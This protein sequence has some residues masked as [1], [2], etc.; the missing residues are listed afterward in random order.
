MMT[1]ESLVI[2]LNIIVDAPAVSTTALVP[3]GSTTRLVLITFIKE[4]N[5][6]IAGIAQNR[7][8]S[9]EV[10]FVRGT[11]SSTHTYTLRSS[12]R[13]GEIESLEL[14]RTN[15]EG[16]L[17]VPR[18]TLQICKGQVERGISNLNYS[19]PYNSI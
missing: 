9:E 10:P 13:R 15:A 8:T 18:R 19:I 16:A 14:R 17:L 6:N 11:R 4:A 12:I 2:W 1:C 3:P 7:D 5:N